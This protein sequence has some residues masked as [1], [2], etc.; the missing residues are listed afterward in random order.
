MNKK[1]FAKYTAK[2]K[3]KLPFWFKIKKIPTENSLGIN[4]LN[5]FGIELDLIEDMLNYAQRQYYIES[6]D[7]GFV[8]IT[9]K[10]VLPTNYN[11]ESIEDI[12][13]SGKVLERTKSL[14]TFFDLNKN[15]HNFSNIAQPDYYYLDE[16]RK[17]IYVRFPYNKSNE[18]KYGEITIRSKDK[19]EDF[20][21]T[22]H[23]VWNFFDEF[24]VLLNCNRIIG[25]SNGSYK[26]RILD[27][28]RNPASSTKVGLSNGIS[29]E[30]NLRQHKVWSDMSKDFVITDSMVI[31]NSIK[32]NNKYIELSSLYVNKDD[33]LI[34]K[35]DKDKAN[36]KG[37]VSYI[38]GLEMYPLNDLTNNKISNELLN[39][40]GTFTDKMKKYISYIRKDCSIIWGDFLYNEAFWD[41][42]KDYDN[43]PY[44]F[45]PA[46]MDSNIKGFLKYNKK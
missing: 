6:A 25:E 34:L 36:I 31:A 23:H 2:I 3:E 45:E 27:V 43:I 21:L 12:I 8:D 41:K 1:Q 20:R 46:R 32:V 15:I 26:E 17:I 11:V 39:S 18:I 40:D 33:Y 10:V 29:R 30:L 22:I 16:T 24:G 37:E 44:G 38:S 28:F 4:F 42:D 5:I 19:R 35:G 13:G 14:Y 7:I 9:Y